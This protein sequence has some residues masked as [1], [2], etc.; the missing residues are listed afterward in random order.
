MNLAEYINGLLHVFEEHGDLPCVYAHDDEG[1][2]FSQVHCN[3][4]VGMMIHEEF[5]SQGHDFEYAREQKIHL[6]PVVNTVCIN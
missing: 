2:G 3:G 6:S 5:W 1:N 4:T